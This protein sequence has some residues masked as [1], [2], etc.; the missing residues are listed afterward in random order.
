MTR[1]IIILLTLLC[2]VSCGEEF[3]NAPIEF[4]LDEIQ[5]QI[6]VVG[7]LVNNE[8]DV[9]TDIEDINN[10]GFF[11]SRSKSVLDS[12]NFEII[13][14]A[15]VNL[16][17]SDGTDISYLLYEDSGYYFPE[18]VGTP[19]LSRL[20]VNDN[21]EYKLT[22]DVPG[23]EL[24]T[25]ICNTRTFGKLESAKVELNDI[26]ADV[27]YTL[28]RLKL[29]INDPPG[30]NYYYL[31]TF[32]KIKE[33]GSDGEVYTRQQQGY[34]YNINSA[35]DGEAKLFTDE[36]FDGT[37][38]TL[39]FWSE[40]YIG[41]N[42]EE[43]I[44]PETIFINLWALTEEEY[45]FRESIR[46]NNEARDNPFAEPSVV[47]NNIENGIGIFSLSKAQITEIKL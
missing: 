18:N 35:L 16:V 42:S 43:A 25:A 29:E 11:I 12:S 10:L 9:F 20:S 4:D 47:F 1:Y 46:R 30:K 17:G 32:Y 38:I 3:F 41:N 44:D 27:N 23:E 24:V 22:V 37:S 8:S 6:S 13:E 40:R 14:N 45:E 15:E 36:L 33:I 31:R 7:R 39:E 28:D 2:T 5:T 26:T 34:I 21:T 19:E